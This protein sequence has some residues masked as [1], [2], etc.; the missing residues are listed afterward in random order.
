MI[1]QFY[2]MLMIHLFFEGSIAELTHVKD[3]MATFVEA[4]GLK[5]NFEKSMMVP[6]NI[7][8]DRLDLL[9]ISFGCFK[10]SFHFTYL[11]LPLSLTKPTTADFWPLATKCERR[12]VT[13]SSFLSEAGRL[14]LT[15]AV[16]TTLPTFAMCSFLLPKTVIKQIDRYRKLCLWR[17]YDLNSKSFLK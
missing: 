8:D 5:V 16:L 1:F 9:A 12:L 14:E 7:R 2:N 17:G 13:F 3:I 10:G 11:G 4:S 15:N 6:V